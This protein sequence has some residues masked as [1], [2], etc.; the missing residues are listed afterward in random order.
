VG[1]LR[2]N[3]KAKNLVYTGKHANRYFWRTY[4]GAELDYVE[5]QGGN[6]RGYEIKYGSGKASVP[7]TWIETYPRHPGE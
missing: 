4:T 7:R 3:R 6:L 2:D 5:A 1:E